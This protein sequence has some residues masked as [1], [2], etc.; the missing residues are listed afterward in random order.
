MAT[1]AVPL[2]VLVAAV[3]VALDL[4]WIT[5]IFAVGGIIAV[6]FGIYT[7]SKAESFPF[8]FQ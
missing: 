4:K 1:G 8:Q 5:F 2:M 6:I 7:Y 3:A